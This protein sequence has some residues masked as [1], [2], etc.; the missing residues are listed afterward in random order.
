MAKDGGDRFQTLPE[1]R[2]SLELSGSWPDSAPSC[3]CSLP[4]LCLSNLHRL[5]GDFEAFA[6][7]GPPQSPVLHADDGPQKQGLRLTETRQGMHAK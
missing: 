6:A 2:L 4:C 5:W 7:G 1:E 3:L